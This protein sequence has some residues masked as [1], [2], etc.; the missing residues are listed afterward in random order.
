MSEED[1]YVDI[2]KDDED[3]DP[4]KFKK[5]PPPPQDYQWGSEP[6]KEPQ[7]DPYAQPDPYKTP[8]PY[9]EGVYQEETY[10]K[11]DPYSQESAPQGDQYSQEYY[12]EGYYQSGSPPGRGPPG[13]ETPWFWIGILIGAGLSAIIM[14][15]F[16]FTGAAFHPLMG[17]IEV[18]LLLVC[19][20]IPGLFVRKAGKGI[21]G[22]MMIFALQFFVPLIVFY[23][24]GTQYSTFFS[25]Y[26]VFLNALGLLSEGM[27]DLLEFSFVP[28]PPEVADVYAQYQGYTSF[29]WIFDL[30]IMFSIMISLI[31]ASSWLFSNVLT[32]KVKKFWTWCVL[33]AQV[34]FI[35]LNL[36]IVPWVLLSL[37]AGVQ[38]AGSLA[39]GAGNIVNAAGPFVGFGDFTGF[40]GLDTEFMLNQ[41]DRASWWFDQAQGSYNGL[42]NMLFFRM[43]KAMTFQYGFI[44]DIFDKTVSAGFELL[45][46]LSPLAH[47]LLDHENYSDVT[48]NG[49]FFQYTEFMETFDSLSGLF[50][51]SGG[52]LA[53]TDAELYD[54]EVSVNGTINNV[55]YLI[56][57]YFH[58]VL[59]HV[60]A[61]DAQLADIDPALM[62]DTGGPA[63]IND[64]LNQVA[65]YLD[66]V[67]NITDQY[68]VLLP[69]ALDLFDAMPDFL[70]GL[71]NMLLGNVRLLFG[72][73]FEA[74]QTYLSKSAD[75]FAVVQSIFTQGQRDNVS[76]S[77][78]ALGFFD[79]FNDTLSLLTPIILE[80]GYLA[81]SLNG[82]VRA[83]DVYVDNSTGTP[84]CDITLV[85]FTEV[86]ANMTYAAGNSSAAIAQG[87]IAS[88]IL[89]TMSDR[90]NNTE[91]SIMSDPATMMISTLTG[92]FQPLEMAQV[93][94]YMTLSINATYA[95]T[96][97]I[98][99][100]DEVNT[101]LQLTLAS[102]EIGNAIAVCDANPDTPVYA[103]K[104]FLEVYQ[105]AITDINGAITPF[106]GGP[107]DII[108]AAPL[109][110][111]L[112]ITLWT[113]IQAL[114]NIQLS[115]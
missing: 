43:L 82:M 107:I 1:F 39:A 72:F 3:D 29:V 61:A 51:T 24:S 115:V 93:I 95:T 75:N 57:N 41:L 111:P 52:G 105:A 11:E 74:C 38:T 5:I 60:V 67:F 63:V 83:L 56:D 27:A 99:Q 98:T 80:E 7:P 8:D 10:P 28:L 17:Y 79:F 94:N 69:L 53:P 54:A 2:L 25:P 12:G 40:E 100:N 49:F 31:I 84:A 44:V 23:A 89:T 73:Q 64:A 4:K 104:G 101:P 32:K 19:T 65:D 113:A 62:R 77:E 22:G 96:Y 92:A 71:F 58:D 46:A 9:K 90:A 86:F 106:L 76:S 68:R 109:V 42:N 33:P 91:Y 36:V 81:G 45:A 21:L 114:V 13:K 108:N 88:T 87:A 15:I 59:G 35:I 18:V 34:V 37:S 66:M 26:F 14:V 85:P 110:D 48:T 103:L 50:N 102:T 78:T 70:R 20:T 47:G 112:M 6:P 55:E 16:H 30:L 97:Y